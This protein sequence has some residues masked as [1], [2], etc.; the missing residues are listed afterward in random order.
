MALFALNLIH[1]QMFS[2]D[3]SESISRLCLKQK[4]SSVASAKVEDSSTK[5]KDGNPFKKP[6]KCN[7]CGGSGF[8]YEETNQVAGT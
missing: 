8:V 2:K 4:Q 6:T 5:Q 3:L 1:L 7:V